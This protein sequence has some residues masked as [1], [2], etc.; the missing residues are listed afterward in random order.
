M[1]TTPLPRHPRW[2]Q[3]ELREHAHGPDAGRRTVFCA[4]EVSSTAPDCASVDMRDRSL[5]RQ[6][7]TSM[8]L[9]IL[10]RRTAQLRFISRKICPLITKIAG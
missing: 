4:G 8:S 3:H 10:Q 7:L 5:T 2:C 6:L 1:R 9:T